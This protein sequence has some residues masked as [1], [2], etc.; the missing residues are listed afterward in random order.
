MIATEIPYPLHLGVTAA[1]PVDTGIVKSALALGALLLEGIGDTIRVSLTGSS[2]REVEAGREILHQ[3]GLDR[4]HPDIVSCPTC[5]RCRGDVNGL[6][7]AVQEHVRG[8]RI[9]LTI[10]VMGCEVNG[11]GEARQA[12]LGLAC[13][14]GGGVLFR[15]GVVTQR[16]SRDTMLQGLLNAVDEELA[17]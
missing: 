1:G 15:K 14:R 11:P 6:V 10:A 3:L 8:R 2:V 13:T 4:A 5:G 16:F 12:D 7:Q 9:P 17:R